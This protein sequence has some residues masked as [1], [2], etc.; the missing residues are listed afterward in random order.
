MMPA[1]SA[2]WNWLCNVCSQTSS[3]T[4]GVA[5]TNNA[6]RTAQRGRNQA[7]LPVTI[8]I[9]G[10]AWKNRAIAIVT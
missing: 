7:A 2:K 10:Q 5:S 1:H 6:A 4:G 3:L 8:T 9:A